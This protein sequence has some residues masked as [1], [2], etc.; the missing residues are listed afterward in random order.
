M[1]CRIGHWG[2]AA[3]LAALA[4]LAPI[5]SAAQPQPVVER[6]DVARVIV[7]VRVV[8]GHGRPV[9]DLGPDDF[10]VRIGGEPVRV[11]SAQWY[12]DD[13]PN[14]GPDRVPLASAGV[15]GFLEPSIRGQLIVFVVQKSLYPQRVLGLMRLLQHSE[16]LL[17]R[18][19]P[20]DRVAVVSFDSHLKIWLDFTDD[21][22]QVRAVL[23]DDVL[24][25][26]PP[27]LEPQDGVSLL[28]TLSQD[29]GR[30][31][32]EI[33]EALRRLGNALE[34]LPGA[35]SVVLVGYGFGQFTVTLGMIG[36][37]LDQRYEEART[38]LEAA[39][40]AV[41]CLGR[42][43]GGLPH[44]RARPGDG[45]GGHGR[46]VRADVPASLARGRSGGQRSRGSLRTLHRATRRRAG[47]PPH[48]GRRAGPRGYRAGAQHLRGVSG[49]AGGVRRQSL[50]SVARSKVAT[51]AGSRASNVEYSRRGGTY[52]ATASPGAGNAI[53]REEDRCVRPWRRQPSL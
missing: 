23:A 35:K 42:D 17:Q 4:S 2:R 53:T 24:F 44:V 37:T 19:T 10:E 25:Q 28:A 5:E 11:E 51:G 46:V 8:D 12:G 38:A 22:D 40:A 30:R 50:G 26:S 27:V 31:T 39:R 33:Q 32:Y 41:F 47:Q 18:V 13:A 48:R 15:T 52:N 29:V 7:D 14:G 34:P 1:H 16:R 43:A 20:R 49:A 3:A 6:V 45:G 9:L 36:A 21:L